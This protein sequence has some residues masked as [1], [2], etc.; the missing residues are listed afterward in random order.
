MGTTD[1]KL[2]YILSE[3]KF[4]CGHPRRGFN[5]IKYVFVTAAVLIFMALMVTQSTE[6][7][8]S[9][10]KKIESTLVQGLQR[11]TYDDNS[12]APELE[13]PSMDIPMP[14]L[15]KFLPNAYLYPNSSAPYRESILAF[16]HNPKSAGTSMKNC[17][18]S[19]TTE[20]NKPTPTVL[21]VD[22]AH[23]VKVSRLNGFTAPS[24]YFMGEAVMGICDFVE[25]RPCSYFTVMREPYERIVSHYYFCKGGGEGW[26]PC[27]NTLEEFTLSLCSLFF[28][29]MTMHLP[30]ERESNETNSPWLCKDHVVTIDHFKTIEKER[31]ATLQY[32]LSNIDKIFAVIGLTEEFETS[33]KLFENIFGE[34]FE[35]CQSE[36][37]NSGLYMD[38]DDIQDKK[39]DR[40][41]IQRE[42]KESL[43]Q[44]EEI[45]K[46][47]HE[48]VMI[49]ERVKEIF[50]E[51]KKILNGS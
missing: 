35:M 36:H 19:I 46:C 45:Q 7:I 28:R 27:D 20:L 29:Q 41:R 31:E 12:E 47:L 42:A 10:F 34:P 37:S 38:G 17:L 2:G 32:V 16:L 5:L 44:N 33:L 39:G 48:D 26:P 49:Y 50:D 22:T 11:N 13:P 25:D 21:A 14:L 43:M 15:H 4:T 30:C 6:F 8:K 40:D 1:F 3:M 18:L 9:H 51:Q 24:E 23:D